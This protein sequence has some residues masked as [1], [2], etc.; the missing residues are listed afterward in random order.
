[1]LSSHADRHRQSAL[2]YFLWLAGRETLD[3]THT[4]SASQN[5]G[6][7]DPVA[8]ALAHRVLSE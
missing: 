6:L 5:S 8:G 4:K 3:K 7:L 1:M 2:A